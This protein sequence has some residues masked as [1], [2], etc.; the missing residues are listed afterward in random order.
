ML[1]FLTVGPLRV[2]LSSEVSW[3]DVNLATGNQMIPGGE[4]KPTHCVARYRLAIIIPF[5]DRD[6]HLRILLRHLLPILQRQLVH[7]R[8]FIVE[9]VGFRLHTYIVRR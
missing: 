9:Q 1:F 5:R 8:V 2:N 3:S 4:W 7:F 6:T